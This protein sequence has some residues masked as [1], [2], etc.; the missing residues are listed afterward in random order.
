MEDD[1]APAPRSIESLRKTWLYIVQNYST[2]NLTFQSDKF[3]AISGIARRMH[4]LLGDDTYL[5]GLW[6]KNLLQGLLWLADRKGKRNTEYV[7][8]SWSWACMITP[9]SYPNDLEDS[10]SVWDFSAC[11][12]ALSDTQTYARQAVAGFCDVTLVT[13]DPFGQVSF[14]V[15]ELTGRWCRVRIE[16]CDN[17]GCYASPETDYAMFSAWATTLLPGVNI[18]TGAFTLAFSDEG[19][20]TCRVT[21]EGDLEFDIQGGVSPHDNNLFSGDAIRFSLDEPPDPETFHQDGKWYTFELQHIMRSYYLMLH[22]D[23]VVG[24][25]YRRIGL[26]NIIELPSNEPS[27]VPNATRGERTIKIC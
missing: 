20:A 25:R 22:Q 4:M 21:E 8:P 12:N 17:A 24:D 7:A 10:S 15:V 18:S 11:D 3:V 19:R 2:R 13:D 5:A 14:G 27:V 26:A 16:G 9:V 6:E 23:I 1:P